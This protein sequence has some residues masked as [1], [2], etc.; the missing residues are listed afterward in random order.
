MMRLIEANALRLEPLVAGHAD[1]MFEPMSE[2][3]IYDYISGE[4]PESVS[5]LRQRYVQLE[6][7]RSADGN[8]RWL[9][10]VVRLNSGQC[11][12][13]VQATIYPGLTGNFAFVFATKYWGSGVA[14]EA[15]Q[16]AL[17]WL[18]R[19]GG[20]LALFATVD[21][22]NDR[23]IRLLARLGFSEVAPAS[24]PHGEVEADDRVFFLR[25]GA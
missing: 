24:Y 23:S 9:N 5:A 2:S 7:G 21:P 8:E 12:G 1:E 6:K 19:H 17:P 25:F 3:A 16:A 10:W 4:P 15:C 18:A 20:V 11:A 22:K 14:F 13:F